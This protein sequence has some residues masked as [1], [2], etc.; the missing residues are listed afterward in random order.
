MSQ[1][2]PICSQKTMK[3]LA[4]ISAVGRDRVGFIHQI[5][6]LVA[7]CSANIS[8]SHMTAMG[9]EFAMLLLVSGNWHAI[10]KLEAD[11]PKL[12][13]REDIR[14]EIHRTEDRGKAED[15]LPYAIDVI[16]LDQPGIVANL[17]SFFATREIEISELNTA[18]YAAAHTG[19]PMFSVQMVISIPSSTQIA[20]LRE[21]FMD[22]CD[23]LNVD[24]IMEPHKTT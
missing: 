18:T 12:A 19:T 1:K 14:V 20:E 4:V 23:E 3:Q 7:D 13:N 16:C 11:L 6:Q 5:S 9:S 2:H 10:A 22:F 21:E 8:E 24:A 15:L 17:S